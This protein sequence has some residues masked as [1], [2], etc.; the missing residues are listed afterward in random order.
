MELNITK[1]MTEDFDEMA[2]LSGSA[3]ELGDDACRVTWK[4][5]LAY[6]A[7]NPLLSPEQIEEARN[8][9]RSYGAWEKEEIDNWTPE[10]I[11]GLATQEIASRIRE[12][13]RYDSF[14]DYEKDSESGRISGGIYQVIVPVGSKDGCE[15]DYFFYLGD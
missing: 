4:N 2:L 10:T 1:M 9:F 5:S 12:F 15:V 3:F 7:K 8:Y 13:E 11:Q 14:E 6:A